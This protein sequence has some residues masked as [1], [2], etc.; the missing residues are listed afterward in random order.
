MQITSGRPT[1]HHPQDLPRASVASLLMGLSQR[2]GF[3][4]LFFCFL[5]CF[6]DEVFKRDIRKEVTF[7]LERCQQGQERPQHAE[8]VRRLRT[9]STST[10]YIFTEI[11][12]NINAYKMPLGMYYIFQ[13]LGKQ[14]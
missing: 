14:V 4:G 2:R 5:L 11:G 1:A 12:L 10:C 3:G 13:I 7:G 6:L 9:I 8:T